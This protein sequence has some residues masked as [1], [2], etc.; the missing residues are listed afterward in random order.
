MV[1]VVEEV[2]FDIPSE[3]ILPND[4]ALCIRDTY[5][6]TQSPYY[7][8]VYDLC[9]PVSGILQ[10]QLLQELIDFSILLLSSSLKSVQ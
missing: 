7:V 6:N 1:V 10:P 5:D 3:A 4:T 9:I 8:C 2:L